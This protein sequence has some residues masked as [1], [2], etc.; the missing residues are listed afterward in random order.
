MA[1]KRKNMHLGAKPSTFINAFLLRNNPT[2]AEIFLWDR[3]KDRQ[4]EGARFRRQHPMKNFVVDNYCN[5][6]KLSI[7]LDGKYH[8]ERS[9]QFYDDDRTEILTENKVTVIRFTNEQ[10]Y[11]SMDSVIEEIR[12]IIISIRE[13]KKKM[14]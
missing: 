10:I 13:Q 11:H 2:E 7:E 6:L 9:Q 3:L 14:K 12:R 8:N 4:V 5:E 1:K